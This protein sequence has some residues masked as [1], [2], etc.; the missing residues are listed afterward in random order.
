[1]RNKLAFL[2]APTIL[3]LLAL[4]A[5]ESDSPGGPPGPTFDAG[6]SDWSA[7]PP[8]FDAGPTPDARPDAPVVPS[9][10]VTVTGPAGPKPGVRVVFHDATGAVIGTKLTGN[11]GKAT[12]TG[13][14]PSMAS[15]LLENGSQ[16]RIVT[17]T[18]VEDGD[19]LQ[20]RAEG[21][22]E[23]VGM[24]NVT[25]ASTPDGGASIYDVAS[26]CGDNSSYGTAT[27]L[28][29]YGYCARP[30]NAVLA[31]ARMFSGTIVGHAF[32]KGN[33]NVT[34]GG[35]GAITVDDWKAPSSLMMTVANVPGEDWFDSELLEIADGAGFRNR[36]ARWEGST[37]AYPTATGFADAYQG[38]FSFREGESER[39]ITKR[40]AP[41]AT[42]IAFDYADLLPLIT[43]AQL[44]GSNPRRPVVSW[45][46]ASSTAGADGGLVHFFFDGSDDA[47]YAWTFVVP[48]SA[49][50]ITAPAMPPE[51]E[52][53]LPPAPDSGVDAR[54]SVPKIVLLEADVL[55][56]YSAFRGQQG[57]LVDAETT[58]FGPTR[59]PA[60]PANGTYRTTAWFAVPR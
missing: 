32:K 11:D 29:L 8:T 3:G 33:A 7:P 26:P 46:A 42:S 43:D 18:G 6:L 23:Q 49:T 22:D 53:F 56:G 36:W 13:A 1:M 55:A 2:F 48:P 14:T 30:K 52:S 12:Q 5:C 31:T 45:T 24:Y 60:L 17:W 28:P 21:S 59:L 51:A 54:F 40:V 19:D 47:S 34:D 39:G 9:V 37:V 38:T 58:G 15:A 35:T 20:V 44:D 50:T 25:F 10:S 27:E 41:T 57:V 16:H 4:A